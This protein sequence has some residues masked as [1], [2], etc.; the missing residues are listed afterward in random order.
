MIGTH[1]SFTGN[2]PKHKFWNLFSFAWKT[3]TKSINEQIAKGAK[4]IDVRIR[5]KKDYWQVCHGLVDINQTYKSIKEI[6]DYFKQ[7]N[8]YIRIILERGPRD[9]FISEIRQYLDE[10][11]LKFV[12]IKEDWTILHDDGSIYVEYYYKPWLSHLTFWQN[13]WTVIKHPYTLKSYAKKHNP[14]ITDQLYSDSLIHFIDYY[15]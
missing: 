13:L 6:I 8:I 14:E 4:F 12:S 3:Q 10:P 2:A 15:D 1:D 7:R 9:R 11:I 5:D